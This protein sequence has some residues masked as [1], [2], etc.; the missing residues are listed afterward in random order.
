MK[1][2]IF[3]LVFVLCASVYSQNFYSKKWKVIES[4]IAAG[5]YKSQ[6]PLLKEIQMMAQ[7]EKNVAQ[8]LK[9]LRAEFEI[10]QRTQDA[11]SNDLA[12]RFFSGLEGFEKGFVGDDSLVFAFIKT[13][14]V[15]DYYRAYAWK[16][17][18]REES[19]ENSLSNIEA[20]S[21]N[22]F[23]SYFTEEY[24]KFYDKKNSLEKLML[25]PYQDI[26]VKGSLDK[27][28]YGTF[29]H[30][31]SVIYVKFLGDS[32]FFTPHELLRNK[33]LVTSIYDGIIAKESGNVKL[34]FSYKKISSVC[35]LFSCNDKITELRSLYNS[36]E[37]GDFKAYIAN[38]IAKYVQGEDKREA[39]AIIKEA[40]KKY[41]K[42]R[43]FAQLKN[44]YNEI[45][46][47]SISLFFERDAEGRKP[48]HLVA[49][50]KNL[51]LFSL[52]IY[53]VTDIPS[54]LAYLNN[55]WDFPITKVKKSKI[56]SV[57]YTLP[58]LQDYSFHKTSLVLGPLPAGA[59]VAEP[60]VEGKSKGYYYFF[61]TDHKLVCHHIP[62]R[63]EENAL[64]RLV[65]SNNGRLAG[66]KSLS[67]LQLTEEGK[68]SN[69]KILPD[70]N[71][72]FQIPKEKGRPYR[73]GLLMPEGTQELILMRFPDVSSKATNFPKDIFSQIFLDRAVYRPGQRVY[74]KTIV[75]KLK[76]TKTFLPEGEKQTIALY[77]ANGQELS[78]QFF[79]TN[80]FGSYSGF[81]G[82]PTGK[83]NGRFYLKIK[84][85]GTSQYF[86]VE[87]YK[88]PKFQIML[89]P[90]KGE[91]SYGETLTLAG[92][93][94][95]YSGVPLAGVT[96]DFEIKK[97][98]P[99]WVYFGGRPNRNTAKNSILGSVKTDKNGGFSFPVTLQK[100]LD[101]DG[102][103]VDNFLVE[104]KV[105]DLNG[106]TQYASTSIR[107]S[108]ASHY[109]RIEGEDQYLS[110]SS[111]LFDIFIR[112]YNEEELN[113]PYHVNLSL[114]KGPERVYRENFSAVIQDLPILSRKVFE[115]K[116][117]RDRFSS[118]KNK[119]EETEHLIIKGRRQGSKVLDLG[120]LKEGKY[121]LEVHTKENR[122]SVKVIREFEVFNTK[123][124]GR[125]QKPFLEVIADKKEYNPGDDAVLYVYSAIK[126]LPV[127]LFV[128]NGMDESLT[129]YITV[130]D[131]ITKYHVK[132]PYD[133]P[134][135]KINIQAQS[136]AFNDIQTKE[137]NLKVD[138]SHDSL[139]VN[140]V[141]FRNTLKPNE[142][143]RWK[144]NI[145]DSRHKKHNAEIL[146]SMYDHSL[147]ALVPHRWNWQKL[148][149]PVQYFS[150]RISQKLS[151]ITYEKILP[152]L[153]EKK[154]SFP[155]FSWM[156]GRALTGRR[157][158]SVKF[159]QKN[160]MSKMSDSAV[161][162][163]L[164]NKANPLE[165]EDSTLDRI[166]VRKD[167]NET[168]FFFPRLYP[169]EKGDFSLMFTSPNAL[170]KWKFMLLA[171]NKEGNVALLEKEVITR[172]EFSVTPNYPR[173]LRSGDE[174]AL[175][176]KISSLYA[177]SISG[178]VKL[179][180]LDAFSGK[181]LTPLFLFSSDSPLKTFSIESGGDA[182]ISW[183]LRVPENISSVIIKI[184]A[185]GGKF[186]DG[187]QKAVLVFPN[188]N[189]ITETLPIFV[190]KG[191]TKNFILENLL[192]YRG[193]SSGG[194]RNVSST[195]E[196][197]TEPL[198]Q[199]ILALPGLK[200]DMHPS[201]EVYFNK[202]FSDILA[203]RLY[204][205]YPR[206]KD[207]F[208]EYKSKNLLISRLQ[209]NPE[210]KTQILEETPW[211][212]Q[213]FDQKEQM[214]NISRLFDLDTFQN[215]IERDW[216]AL[217]T[218]QNPDGGF[219]W[220]L[221]SRSSVYMSLYI[222]KKW[223]KI[224]RW[225]GEDFFAYQN[226]HGKKVL[227][228]LISY[229]DKE[230]SRKAY[231]TS[232]SLFDDLLL[233]YLDARRFWE[234][235]YPFQNKILVVKNNFIRGLSK[236]T[237]NDFTFYGLHRA[238]L[239]AYYF[240]Q[241]KISDSFLR[242]LKETA[243]ETETKGTYWKENTNQWGWYPNQISNQAGVIEAFE[244]LA[245]EDR[246]FIESLKVWL[247]TH[248]KVN[249]WS[250]PRATAEVIF[251]LLDLDGDA[252]PSFSSQK[253]IFVIK[254]GNKKIESQKKITG[255][256]KEVIVSEKADPLLAEVSVKNET[257]NVIQG[258]LFWQYYQ[259]LDKIKSG[260]KT[261]S[262]SKEL[263]KN[264]KTENGNIAEKVSPGTL[265]KVGDRLTVQLIINTD[266]PMQYIHIKDMR[267]AGFEPVENLSRYF[268]KEGLGYYFTTKDAS[269]H[270]YIENIE[271][272]KY[273]FTY[274]VVCM[275]S[276]FFGSG[277]A[278]LENY[279]APEMQAHS[280]GEKVK[281]DK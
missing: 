114:L 37:S 41:P 267:A 129:K 218:F 113:K 174:L 36:L 159:A 175:Q 146:V 9:S 87:E 199:V 181:T 193:T 123:H 276:G 205:K 232:E 98:D 279:Y 31:F 152:Y 237:K 118:S 215:A 94:C 33:T 252:S 231:S 245:P 110:D 122:D 90:V 183:K 137:I 214:E 97:Q 57:K 262:I 3:L 66:V 48:I 261:F 224:K 221:G 52:K 171:N 186:S 141:V 271:K 23:K 126:N 196:L 124:L 149:P 230:I 187:E 39:L 136:V 240:K 241:K 53:R 38:E 195:L 223:G 131:G 49:D 29:Y 182:V 211:L 144:F 139:V 40:Q 44:S 7:K 143:E 280:A 47:P 58:S 281:I 140:T 217:L 273:L 106:E 142:Q 30:W 135:G 246:N 233:D 78:S 227:S 26:F 95:G 111:V 151:E 84:E 248:K 20:W 255:Y 225:L 117:P 75:Q 101:K 153:A 147:D 274:D 191:Q 112:N 265:V 76:D 51:P 219:S 1:N 250:N 14:F 34:Y 173:F 13:Q 18:R 10:L 157:M 100:D 69:T 207:V 275:T 268:W 170:G 165:R 103:P 64:W 249:A 164:E 222:L 247:I 70:G 108:S 127:A 67:L 92:K 239:L 202:W 46:N 242:Y 17:N 209:Q 266:R 259:D 263:Y 68:F 27:E 208:E 192:K 212:A 15:R 206:L 74:F 270:F 50:A 251:T 150:Y 6:L 172:K 148:Q 16:I 238:A 88:T 244:V 204:K 5:A 133:V 19:V 89:D 226:N 179:E 166:V 42:T 93:V 254:W 161:S 229:V 185:Q 60:V 22:A 269:T 210:L 63:D 201:S 83:L 8:L 43:F 134:K 25:S 167:I 24:K 102:A 21:K 54:L 96:V 109:I 116:F 55:P 160:K 115:E 243:I 4:N 91:Y 260:G 234:K 85:T 72:I 128:Q 200:N 177:H 145:L 132:V 253:N 62:E 104:T 176:S 197:Y 121:R 120:K 236:K 138:L 32:S 56:R 156:E 228:S 235:E 256:I 119:T 203:S 180:V 86:Y 107:V 188:K 258:G 257:S 158:Y 277:I 28:Y 79:T 2:I 11:P 184:V 73:K 194:I 216:E 80:A 155:V 105:T 81:F 272:G 168:A 169:D 45:T 190:E 178:I 35:G 71:G 163:S 264:I 154:I 162:T 220:I 213:S 59:Y 12:S 130:R 278:T 82:L 99:L 198:W 125:N 189:L 65:E 77:D 61:V